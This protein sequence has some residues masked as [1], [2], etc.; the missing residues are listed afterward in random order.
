MFSGNCDSHKNGPEE[1]STKI[2]VTLERIML[3]NAEIRCPVDTLST[4]IWPMA[5]DYA[6]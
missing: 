2:Y 5:I 6:A 4:D 1:C 3:M